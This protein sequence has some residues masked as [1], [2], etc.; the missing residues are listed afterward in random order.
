MKDFLKQNSLLAIVFLT[1]AA[2]LLIEVSA[3]R[4]L[5]PYFGNTIYSVSSVLGVILAALSIGYY[6]GGKLSD[7]HPTTSWF[8]GIIFTSGLSVLALQLLSSVLLPLIGYELSFVYGP[9][10]TSGLLFLI[11]A[12]LMGMLSPYVIT[13]QQKRAPKVGIGTISG[14]VFFWSTLGSIVGSLGT[15]FFLIPNFGINE[16]V[17]A[18]GIGLIMLGGIP[19]IGTKKRVGMQVLGWAIF[20]SFGFGLLVV[21]AAQVEVLYQADGV[22]EKITIEDTMYRDRP[23]RLLRQDRSLSGAMFPDSDELVFDYTKYYG[24]YRIFSPEPEKALFIGGGSYTLPMALL[25]EDQSVE[26]DVVEIEPSL[27]DLAKT[28]FNATDDPRLE[29]FVLD[30]RRFLH[31]S[32]ESYD[33]IYSDVYRSH[34]SIPSHMTTTEFFEV[35]KERL[36]EDGVFM[37][38]IIG[39][40][41]RQSPSLLWSE[42][43]TFK[44]VFPNMYIFPVTDDRSLQNQNII[45]VGFNGDKTFTKEDFAS[46]PDQFV[47]S[48]ASKLLDLDR[49]DPSTNQILSDNY[50]PV[51]KLTSVMINNTN[52]I[53]N[54]EVN[55]AEMLEL[56]NQQVL[57]GPRFIGS[58]GHKK[59]IDLIRAELQANTDEVVEQQFSEVVFDSPSELT[60][61]IGRVNPEAED[62]LILGTH[63]D[64][65]QFAELDST[66]PD[67]PVPG[68]NDGA[69]GVA[70]LLDVARA[71]SFNNLPPDVGVDFVFF[72]G[73]EG[74]PNINGTKSWAPYGS[75]YFSD[76]LDDLYDSPPTEAIIVDMVC[77]DFL[78][79][80][81][82]PS[83][84]ESAPNIIDSVWSIGKQINP[85]IFVDREGLS[86][87][88]DHTPLQ[89]AGIPSILL[90][91]YNYSDF[92]TTQDLPKNC[93]AN[94]LEVVGETLLTYVISK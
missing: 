26:I 89:K 33:L 11:P 74:D 61:I 29:N 64:T 9:L 43:A 84:V 27:F 21:N 94:S 31:D 78:R 59:T 52:I 10:V 91:D 67:S 90:L 55:G 38:N 62:R 20:L 71:L 60:N 24:L 85:L 83:S 54:N 73:E 41:S 23:T 93:N 25:N 79:L 72:D 18:T 57:Y 68:A 87:L 58:E 80:K 76:H 37:A 82:E 7:R 22:Y 48:T 77:K 49:F 36:N 63:F 44:S 14:K 88:D 16:I 92:H 46:H 15:G 5:S 12:F 51:D 50:A 45:V 2:V 65:K 35:A 69:S 81:K 6:V 34:F 4:I 53:S 40:T 39:R 66:S 75:V 13:L 56:I 17:I 86:I 42:I 70:V 47:Q 3:I 30:G 19:L 28:Y 1:G 8:Y 32:T